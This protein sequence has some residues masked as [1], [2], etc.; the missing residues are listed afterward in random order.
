MSAASGW[1]V[2]RV[3]VQHAQDLGHDGQL[4]IDRGV[5]SFTF[6]AATL[7]VKAKVSMS[8]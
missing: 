2:F 5:V 4:L 1:T 8:V 7:G 3:V 6:L